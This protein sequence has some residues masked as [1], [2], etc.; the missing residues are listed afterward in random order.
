MTILGY[1]AY[2]IGT[3]NVDVSDYIIGSLI[4]PRQVQYNDDFSPIYPALNFNAINTTG[5][6][7]YFAEDEIIGF[8]V[9]SD[10]IYYCRVTDL[11]LNPVSKVYDVITE[12]IFNVLN[13]TKTTA[14]AFTDAVTDE[15]TDYYNLTTQIVIKS[16]R[17][18]K[19]M[20][21]IL[22]II[23]QITTVTWS[24]GTG[25]QAELE[26]YFLNVD[27]I[28]YLGSIDYTE[29]LES[30]LTTVSDLFKELVKAFGFVI[31]LADATATV[32]YKWDST[33]LND[34]IYVDYTTNGSSPDYLSGKYVNEL[35]RSYNKA[36]VFGEVNISLKYYRSLLYYS[37]GIK[38][39]V[40]DIVESGSD[41]EIISIDN[42]PFGYESTNDIYE[43]T[44]RTI[45][46]VRI[47]NDL[48]LSSDYSLLEDEMSFDVYPY[49]VNILNKT[50]TDTR[51][52]QVFTAASTKNSSTTTFSENELIIDIGNNVVTHDFIYI[53]LATNTEFNG[54]YKVDANLLSD[55]SWKQD[56]SDINHVL[57]TLKNTSIAGT[58]TDNQAIVIVEMTGGANKFIKETLADA[59]NTL[60]NFG[61]AH[62][63]SSGYIYLGNCACEQDWR[64]YK[65]T[66]GTLAIAEFEV[67][68]TT[69]IR[70]FGNLPAY[71]D[72]MTVQTLF[73]SE[74]FVDEE[75]TVLRDWGEIEQKRVLNVGNKEKSKEVNLMDH[76][77]IF[78][79]NYTW[80]LL[81][82]LD[83]RYIYG[84]GSLTTS[85]LIAFLATLN[86][87]AN[88]I[89]TENVNIDD[90]I[91]SG[92]ALQKSKTWDPKDHSIS[93]NQI[94]IDT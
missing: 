70:L 38:N 31:E 19:L 14:L 1:K 23:P 51:Y 52:I 94:R 12:N 53:T 71:D 13:D 65:F 46:G 61:A 68:N 49:K 43:A 73:N 63:L 83:P 58:E 75:T 42:R 11:R 27:C 56:A 54:G 33:A 36:K 80:L 3:P 93:I 20:E 67:V 69:K 81:Y 22:K 76:L 72:I 41:L 37:G 44:H 2:Q 92:T 88:T 40:A 35:Q 66:S 39:K 89:I 24:F 32:S 21:E 48:A 77:V 7:T 29:E 18:D 84:I 64:I 90:E 78:Q 74:E 91:S 86:T 8:E 82:Y 10:I 55:R 59:T 17:I 50:L 9:G 85:N 30:N 6:S 34:L 16:I 60:M 4:I 62:S 5:V 47:K 57:V 28:K 26:K 15:T 79:K 25:S 87:A 45:K